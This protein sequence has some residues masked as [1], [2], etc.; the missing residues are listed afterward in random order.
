LQRGIAEFWG[1]VELRGCV[2]NR[3]PVL[4]CNIAVGGASSRATIAIQKGATRARKAEEA[5]NTWQV[6]TDEE[7]GC[8]K[9]ENTEKCCSRNRKVLA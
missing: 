4:T 2:V 5:C 6:R 8:S 3:I 1:P 7:L 9:N